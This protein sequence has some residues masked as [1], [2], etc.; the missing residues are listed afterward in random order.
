V[1]ATKKPKVTPLAQ[2]L[3]GKA[4]QSPLTLFELATAKWLRGERLEL[5][6][7]ASELGVARTTVFRWVGTREQLYGEV[8]SASYA[9]LHEHVLR[10][11]SGRGL[12]RLTQV[13]RRTLTTLFEAPPLR[14]FLA[15]DPEFAIRVLTSKSSAVQARS[16]QLQVELL[17]EVLREADIR[18][19]LDLET[20]AFIVVRISEAFLYADVISCR[21]P[22]IDKAVAAVRILVA[23]AGKVSASRTDTAKRAGRVKGR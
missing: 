20:L 11:T 2:S 15:E 19:S 14:T 7:L 6:Q 8:L 5:T 1:K 16:I 3:R 10:T 12:Q 21:K 4:R 17:R 18:S 9:R 23:G 22:E 13:T